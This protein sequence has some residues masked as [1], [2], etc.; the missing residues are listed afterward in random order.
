MK[1]LQL[2]ATTEQSE[3]NSASPGTGSWTRRPHRTN[4][5]PRPSVL[6]FT[7]RPPERLIY[8]LTRSH[9]TQRARL[10]AEVHRDELGPECDHF[11][12][13][14]ETLMVDVSYGDDHGRKLLFVF[15]VQVGN[16]T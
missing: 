14:L 9:L 13:H 4:S 1:D 7:Q 15:F 10:A 6:L 3:E 16:F 12:F 8:K 2:L 5:V 11:L